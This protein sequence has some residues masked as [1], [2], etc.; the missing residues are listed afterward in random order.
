MIGEVVGGYRLVQKLGEGSMGEVYLGEHEQGRQKAAVKVLFPPF[1]KEGTALT[2]YFAEVRSTNL[3]GHPGIAKVHDCGIHASG[4]AFLAME[5]LDGK[6]LAQ[7]LADLGSVA[8]I[9]TLA[10]IASQV[11]SALQAVHGKRM[12]HRAL[13]TDSIFMTFPSQELVIKLLDFGVAKTA[14]APLKPGS[15]PDETVTKV[16]TGAHRRRDQDSLIPE[17]CSAAPLG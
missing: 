17:M 7:A 1:S 4:R 15:S 14:E 3:F 13:K 12:V 2:R 6:S 10:Q 8:E 9:T 16:L 11:A 5:Y